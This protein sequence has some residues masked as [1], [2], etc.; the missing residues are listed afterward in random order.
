MS[1]AK[2]KITKDITINLVVVYKEGDIIEN[3]ERQEQGWRKYT[4]TA[5]VYIAPNC[6]YEV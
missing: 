2:I 3:V 1:N 5:T 6:A 4:G